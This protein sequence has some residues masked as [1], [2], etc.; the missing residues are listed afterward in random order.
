MK[1]KILIIGLAIFILLAVYLLVAHHIIYKRIGGAGLMATNTKG[2]YFIKSSV[3]NAPTL[4][5]TALGDSLTAGVGV[6]N[7]EQSYP[8]LLAKKFAG[9]GSNI[10]LHPQ[11][12]P[13]ARTSDLIR[14]FLTP[15]INDKPDIVTVVIGVNDVHG[16]VSQAQFTKNYQL[17]LNRLKKETKAK[18]YAVSIPYIGSD[19]LLIFP[20]NLYFKHETEQYNKIIKKLAQEDGIQ[21]VDLFTP[22]ENMYQD[23]AFYSSDSFHPSAKGYEFWAGIIYADLNK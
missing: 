15:A 13:G 17:I 23:S 7:F 12:Y 3:D 2:Q 14:D 19:S 4:V 10:N 8:Y 16:F 1:N 18:I 21:Y 9:S 11:A 20:Y 22:A 5:Y 6:E